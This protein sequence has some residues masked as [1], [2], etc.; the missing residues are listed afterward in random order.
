MHRLSIDF[1][2]VRDAILLFLGV[3]AVLLLGIETAFDFNDEVLI[4]IENVD[5]FICAVFLLDWIFSLLL[6]V[7]KHAYIKRNWLFLIAAIPYVQTLR[8]F[9]MFRVVRLLNILKI[10]Q[11]L[12]G[13]LPMLRYVTK[14]K[15]RSAVALYLTLTI[16]ISLYCGIGL[17]LFE[18]GANTRIGTDGDVLWM[19]FTTLTLSKDIVPM[20]GEGR[21]LSAMLVI[22]GMGLFSLFLAELS[23]IFIQYVQRER[24]EDDEARLKKRRAKKRVSRT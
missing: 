23:S 18:K 2:R 3:V 21:L 22:T 14:N 15:K 11:A 6:S 16:F 8:L 19:A 20:T 4:V 1:K 13:F 24:E 7:D 5:L 12:K 10:T 17:Y 9:Q